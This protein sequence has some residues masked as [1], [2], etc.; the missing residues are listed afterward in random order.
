MQLY[1]L[2]ALYM[3]NITMTIVMHIKATQISPYKLL[4]D[5]ADWKILS[6]TYSSLKNEK[7]SFISVF[8]EGLG[9]RF[10]K[11]V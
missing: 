11:S 1:V 3:K 9:I 8:A 2:I 7:L 6:N 10:I 5:T 4:H